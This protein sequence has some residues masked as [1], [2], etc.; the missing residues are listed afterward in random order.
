ML[1]IFYINKRKNKKHEATSSKQET[2]VDEFEPLPIDSFISIDL[3]ARNCPIS[4]EASIELLA[5]YLQR[6]A[7]TD[8]EKARSIYIWLTK[9]VSYDDIGFNSGIYGDLSAEGV[10]KSRKAVCEGFSN[11]FLA[12]GKQMKLEIQKVSGY[13]KGYGYE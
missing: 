11:L 3:H 5:N 12:L 7:I 9:N 4:E 10:L 13:A 8:L 2:E 6:K 1:R